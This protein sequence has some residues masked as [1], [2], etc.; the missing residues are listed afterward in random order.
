MAYLTP[1]NVQAWLQSTKYEITVVNTDFEA[2]SRLKAFGKLEQ[3]YDTSVWTDNTNTPGLVLSAISMMVAAAELRRIVSE[4]DGLASHAQWLEDRAM[5]IIEGIVSGAIE[6]PG[7]DPDPASTLGGGPLFFPNDVA[8]E[9]AK[10]W[11][12]DPVGAPRAFA[13]N[14]RF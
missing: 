7:V 14:E 9:A 1:Q 10:V 13:M 6:L 12:W 8:T 4:E 5:A 3:R 2:A 11:E